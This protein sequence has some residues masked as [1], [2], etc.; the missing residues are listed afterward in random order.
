MA[1]T[2]RLS[3]TQ[4]PQSWTRTPAS[5]LP[6]PV[7]EARSF[8]WFLFM[9]NF[10]RTSAE[11]WE[12]AVPGHPDLTCAIFFFFLRGGHRGKVG[13]GLVGCQCVRPPLS[14]RVRQ[15]WRVLPGTWK[16]VPGARRAA[17]SSP[18]GACAMSGCR[19]FVAKVTPLEKVPVTRC[20][21]QAVLCLGSKYSL[22]SV[23]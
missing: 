6:G 14:L 5:T 10:T 4:R 7:S 2:P 12:P 1:V 3:P 17:V 22:A 15:C 16:P 8:S 18:E 23:E 21:V 9:L 11:C 20:Q 13:S 19:R